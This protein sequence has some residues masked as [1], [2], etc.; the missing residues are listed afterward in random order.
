MGTRPTAAG[1]RLTAARGTEA[2]DALGGQ[3]KLPP[4]GPAT[5][6]TSDAGE[7]LTATA[8]VVIGVVF[9]AGAADYSDAAR[10]WPM[11]L[12]YVVV[13]LGVVNLL[14]LVYRRA[15]PDRRS[16]SP[17]TPPAADGDAAAGASATAATAGPDPVTV[18]AGSRRQIATGLFCLAYAG[19]GYAAGFLIATA[20]LLP[21]YLLL[22]F[23]KR[24]P[25]LAAG[26]TAAVLAFM[27][28]VF[29]GALNAPLERG[30]WV[31]I[32]LSWLPF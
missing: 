4:E 16:T 15:I 11:F 2:P 7:Y 29:G 5:G 8:F 30:V 17:G 9:W 25:L 23:P 31:G 24:R 20:V 13:G 21:L 12:S 18:R 10:R 27:Y 1:R 28:L 22:S 19:L 32:D 14:A 3:D 6:R 26:V